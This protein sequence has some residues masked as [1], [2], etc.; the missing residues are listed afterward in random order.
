MTPLPEP[1]RPTPE[2]LAALRQGKSTLHGERRAMVLPDKV[3][4]VIELQ[5]ACLPLLARQRPLQ[6]WER[7]WEAEA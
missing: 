6:A 2:L 1:A 3:R 5:Q 7:V 4:A